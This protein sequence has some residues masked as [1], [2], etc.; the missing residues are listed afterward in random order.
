[1]TAALIMIVF[2][3][4]CLLMYTKKMNAMIALPIMA[5]A[6]ALIAG[7][8]WSDVAKADGTKLPGIQTLLFVDGPARLSSTMITFIFGAILA[9]LVSDTGIAESVIREVSEL[10]GDRPLVLAIAMFAALSFLFTILGGLGAVILLGTI[11]LPILISVGVEPVVAGVILIFANSVGG[12][13]NIANWSVYIET[14]HLTQDT[15]FEYAKF[16]GGIFAVLG[17]LFIVIEVKFHGLSGIRK[18][19]AGSAAWSV[20]KTDGEKTAFKKVP[21]YSVITLF[22]PII[23]V[24]GFKLNI[25]FAFVLGICYAYFTT[26]KKNSPGQLIK[27]VLNGIS[28]SAGA[29]FLLI[30]IGM[31]LKV[32]MDAR[33]TSVLSPVLS[34]VLPKSAPGYVVFFTL[35]APLALYRGP[36]NIW[37]LGLGLAS[38]M[39]ATGNFTASAMMAALL[40]TGQ[41]QGICDPTNTYNVW[42]AGCVQTDVNNLMTKVLPYVWTGV[43]LAL[44]V[45]SALYF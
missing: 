11:V 17:I 37:G 31:L 23:A 12:T 6:I 43:F 45:A 34:S 14:L 5:L 25:N 35:L 10:V 1:M 30:S 21:W 8:P 7:I 27:A 20:P 29:L 4:I 42:T 38:I 19:T 44:M 3:L 9:Q 16:C 18:K 41:M 28:S 2:I 26:L 39:A 24:V 32:V 22:I 40:S 33:V 36:L 13:F 15:V